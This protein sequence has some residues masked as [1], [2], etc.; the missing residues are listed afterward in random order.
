MVSVIIPA[1][2]AAQYLEECLASVEGQTFPD[3]EAIVVDDGSADDTA[4]IASSFVRRDSRFR[5]LSLPN[6]GVSRARN[7]GIELARG[8]YLTFVDADD[9]MAP[10]ML[11]DLLAAARSEGA[12]VVISAFT[13]S[14]AKFRRLCEKQNKRLP[15][16]VNYTY[17][18][19]MEAAL[20]QKRLLNSPW[21]AIISRKLL[22]SP[23]R[24]FRAGTRYEDLDAFYRLYEG[25][26]RIA[27]IGA[28]YYFYR[29][30]PDSFIHKWSEAR[31]D[32]LDVTD[33]LARFM[34]ERYPGLW[35]AAADRRFSAHF[36]MLLLMEKHRVG[37]PEAKQRCLRVIRDGRSR[38]L[39]NP[40]VRLKNKAGALL[41]YL[42]APALRLM[43]RIY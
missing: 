34:D 7:A 42:G 2:N 29:N 15:V 28:P 11:E 22:E 40:K 19:A 8:E 36:N 23:D 24:R 4:A 21:G 9:I 31:L 32:V 33:R 27:Y 37:N 10:R 35:E 18:E 13:S 39:R 16:I 41:A 12:D 26:S 6:G 17:E 14:P 5:L 30:N 25:A 1:Y 38:A 20:Y 3:F 43:S